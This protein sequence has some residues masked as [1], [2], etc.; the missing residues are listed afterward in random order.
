MWCLAPQIQLKAIPKY[1]FVGIGSEENNYL[2]NTATF[3]GSSN[4]IRRNASFSN[5]AIDGKVL[6]FAFWIKMN[7]ASSDSTLYRI[8]DTATGG[9][10]SRVNID[11]NTDGTLRIRAYN[12]SSL[13]I[14]RIASTDTFL[15]ADGWKH[16][17]VSVDLTNTSNRKIYVNGVS[18]T[19][20]VTTY[21]NTQGNIDL[22][23][24]GQ[25]TNIG[26]TVSGNN[27]LYGSLAE[28]WGDDVYL[29]DP[30]KFYNA[31]EPVNLGTDGSSP[32]GIQPLFYF[33]SNGSGDS[34]VNNG[35]AGTFVITG[36]LGTDTSP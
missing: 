8:F 9:A 20:T 36:S 10:A 3:N 22:V 14:L 11:R 23:A 6:T 27:K 32:N 15:A 30:T 35:T 2:V 4:Y 12:S 5:G 26:S 16:F 19:I 25:Q 13:E 7:A 33:S 24:T 17:Y 1:F 29:D 28:F 18:D 34:W 21:D 31:G